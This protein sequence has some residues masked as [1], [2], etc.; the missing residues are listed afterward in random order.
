[1]LLLLLWRR[2]RRPSFLE[3][4]VELQ[5]LLTLFEKKERVGNCGKVLQKGNTCF[6]LKQF[7]F[8]STKISITFLCFVLICFQ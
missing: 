7:D 1:M 6:L 5:L 4:F 3:V 8:V 2:A